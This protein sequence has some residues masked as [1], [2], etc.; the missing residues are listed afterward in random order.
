M[1]RVIVDQR[2]RRFAEPPGWLSVV[3]GKSYVDDGRLKPS[4]SVNFAMNLNLIESHMIDL[5]Y[6][7][8]PLFMSL[9]TLAGLT[10]VVLMVNLSVRLARKESV[11]L[12]KMKIIPVAGSTAFMLGLLAQVIGIYQM[13]SAIQEAGDVSPALIMGGFQVTLIAPA[14]GLVLFIVSLIGYLALNMIHR[15]STEIGEKR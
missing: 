8:G 5:F 15:S 4:D 10:S 1:L 14:Y 12:S 2:Q 9:V 6:R 3:V 7:G 13:I 11:P